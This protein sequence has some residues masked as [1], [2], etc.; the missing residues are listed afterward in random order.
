MQRDQKGRAA[1][2]IVRLYMGTM[3]HIRN[4]A[5]RLAGVEIKSYCWLRSI[6]IPRNWEDVTLDGCSLD[7]G[8]VLLCS[9]SAKK[10]KIRIGKNTYINRYTM[11]D[12]HDAV[13]I[14]RN[15]LIGPHC[16][17]TDGNHGIA[18]TGIVKS[19]PMT[20][21]PVCI[22]DGVWIG[23]QVTILPGVTIGPGAVIAAGAVVTA[24]VEPNV[25]VAGVPARKIR[26]RT[27]R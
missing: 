14:G 25:V 15:V 13:E 16:F 12:A 2:K 3:S 6:E 9:G 21:K 1:E 8:V 23:A 19:Q 26:L 27:E 7:R 11:I 18:G 10:H 24:D 22:H 5:F 17:I 4:V 20:T